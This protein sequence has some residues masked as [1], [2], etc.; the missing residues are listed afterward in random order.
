[1]VQ[2]IEGPFGVDVQVKPRR[3]PNRRRSNGDKNVKD[4][5]VETGA[6]VDRV[7]LGNAGVNTGNYGP[8]GRRVFEGGGLGEQVRGEIT[9][10]SFGRNRRKPSR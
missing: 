8:N 3:N 5:S 6:R 7:T 4:V 9:E 1:M 2:R 10:A